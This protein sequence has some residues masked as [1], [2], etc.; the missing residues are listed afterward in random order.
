MKK[1]LETGDVARRLKTSD[2]TVRNLERKGILHADRTASGTR[3]FDADE[4][5]RVKRER[6]EKK[7]N[8]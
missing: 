6:A 8:R 2:D 7:K 4:V 5:E 1:P 3:L